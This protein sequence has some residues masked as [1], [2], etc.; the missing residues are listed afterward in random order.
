[1]STMTMIGLGGSLVVNDDEDRPNSS[2]GRIRHFETVRD[3]TVSKWVKP[4]ARD[5]LGID[6]RLTFPRDDDVTSAL[7]DDPPRSK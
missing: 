7:A 1:M 4:P 2:I 5:L 3:R 6:G